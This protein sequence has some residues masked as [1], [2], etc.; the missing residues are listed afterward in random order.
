M[1]SVRLGSNLHLMSTPSGR[2]EYPPLLPIGMHLMTVGQLRSLCVNRF[3]LSTTRDKI[4]SGLEAVIEALRKQG[5]VGEVWVDGSFV[6]EK[7]NPKDS[8]ILLHVEGNFY[9]NAT[10]EQRAV[11]DWVNDEDLETPY[12]CD[13]YVYFDY[14][15]GHPWYWVGVYFLAYWMKQYGFSRDDA[16]GAPLY[17]KGIAVIQL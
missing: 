5:V 6:T 4:M 2:K 9:D 1:I 17:Y 7:I 14:P 8:D 10:P 15:A 13:S 3:P 11:V 16:S 12:D